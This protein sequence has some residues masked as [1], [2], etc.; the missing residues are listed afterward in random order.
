VTENL[1][2]EDVDEDQADELTDD[3]IVALPVFQP[4]VPGARPWSRAELEQLLDEHT[5]QQVRNLSDAVAA[6]GRASA[7]VDQAVRSARSAG[8]SWADVARTVGI[9]RQAAQQ[10]WGR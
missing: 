9:S 5:Q 7:A 1:P 6:F 3:T 2:P 8:A 10:R 4:E